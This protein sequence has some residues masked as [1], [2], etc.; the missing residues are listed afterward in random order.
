MLAVTAIGSLGTT[1][2]WLR[3]PSIPPPSS[4][5]VACR[6]FVDGRKV[7]SASVAKSKCR[8]LAMS[9]APISVRFA[10]SIWHAN[11]WGNNSVKCIGLSP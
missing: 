1:K 7:L 2:P 8:S 3:L 9:E 5:V 4:L 6:Y 10:P 11:Y